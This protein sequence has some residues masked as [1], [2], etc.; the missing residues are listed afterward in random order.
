MIEFRRILCPTDFSDQS[1][2]ALDKAIAIA[3][4]YE[5]AVTVLHVFTPVAVERYA[6]DPLGF[7]PVAMLPVDRD[8]LLA[9]LRAFCAAE[10]APGIVID[11]VLREGRV[12]REILDQADR[13][14]ADLLVLG[15]HGRSG[16]E[17][18]AL[19]SVA[20]KVLRQAK[21]PVLTV[22]PGLPDA[23]PAAAGLFKEIL[24]A[25]DFSDGTEH[26]VSY[27]LSLAQEA[28]ARLTL[29][30]VVSEHFD[31]ALDMAGLAAADHM[32]VGDFRRQREDALQE[33][34]ASLVPETAQTYCEVLPLLTH[35]RPWVE[36]LRI[37]AVQ[38][39]DLIV[40]GVR[41]RSA[42]DLMVFGST[43]HHVVREATCPV[44]TLRR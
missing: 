39:A 37:A 1:R 6:P 10:S 28:D 35:G 15:T 19:G 40:M 32:S 41:G 12:A 29:L 44:L 33:R 16:F 26:A 14:K 25:V 30:H 31:S 18:L 8:Q 23:V 36:I 17:R 20:E 9:D 38:N 4:W 5:S 34:L 2:R 43:T 3:R 11:P 24:C 42:A 22:P 27:A 21:C 7:A 13:T